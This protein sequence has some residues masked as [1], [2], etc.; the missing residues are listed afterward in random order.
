MMQEI[1]QKNRKVLIQALSALAIF[2]VASN[3]ARGDRSEHEK[4]LLLYEE[5]AQVVAQ[6]LDELD[7]IVDVERKSR[8]ALE[9][10]NQDLLKKL[11]IS[12]SASHQPSR[13]E[14]SVSTD[15]KRAKDLVWNGFRESANRN[16]MVTPAEIPNFDERG[17][18]TLEQWADRYLLLEVLDRFVKVCLQGGISRI[19]Q[20]APG[21]RIQEPLEDEKKVLARYP[22]NVKIVCS[23]EQLSELLVRFQRDGGFLSLEPSR[24]VPEKNGGNLVEVDL[25]VA[26]IDME[27]PREENT[28][29]R[30]GTGRSRGGF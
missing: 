21:S 11:G 25:V 20:V 7:G 6:D 24:V 1:W 22:I 12:Y 2:L 8:S 13:D 30:R 16:G 26:G 27:D 17:D 18:L 3:L 14:A 15:F 4:Y 10:R 5:D 28:P 29:N 9:A 23:P 19:D